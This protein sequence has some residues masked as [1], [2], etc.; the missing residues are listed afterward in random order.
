MGTEIDS[1]EI[2]IQADARSASKA[3]EQLDK[4][5][6]QVEEA[7]QETGNASTTGFSKLSKGAQNLTSKL[8]AA[9]GGLRD[10]GAPAV[11][12]TSAF[13]KTYLAV[14]TLSE[15]FDFLKDSIKSSMDAIET[16]NFY[17]VS[18]SKVGEEYAS[19]FE[20]FGYESA[21]A[22]VES[23]EDRLND[24]NKKLTGYTIGAQGEAILSNNVGLGL[25][26]EQMQSYQAQVLSFTNAIGLVG[27]ASINTTKA[28][29]MLSGDVASLTNKDLEG[30]MTDLR[31]VLQ[32]QS[33]AG[34]KYGWDTTQATLQQYALAEGITKSISE[35]TQAEKVQLRLLAVLDQSEVS[36]SDL[37]NTLGSVANQSRLTGQQI[38]NFSRT[39]GNLFLPAVKNVLPYINGMIIAMNNLFTTLGFDMYGDT[40]LSDLQDGITGGVIEGVED[41]EESTDSTTDSVNKLK[42]SLAGFDELAILN[43]GSVG[44]GVADGA[45]GVIDLTE[46]ITSA[47]T[48]YEKQWE[49]AFALA[50]NKAADFAEEI[51]VGL[52]G[53][54]DAAERVIPAVLG[55]GTAFTAYKVAGGFSA[56]LNAL[57]KLASP[58]GV[59]ALAA[60]SIV[61][62]SSAVKGLNDELAKEDLALRFGEVTLS[63]KDIDK[64]AEHIL[65][66]KSLEKVSRLLSELDKTSGIGDD[67][68]RIV[69]ELDRYNWSV[70]V[71][72]EIGEEY[73]GKYKKAVSDYV[74]EVNN[75]VTQQHYAATLGVNLF[76]SN[77]ETSA[78]I[79]NIVN[80]FYNQQSGKL[81]EL[82]KQL[83]EVTT[84]AWNDGLLTIDEVEA[85]TNIQQ[86]MASIQEQL[87]TSEFKARMQL[88]EMD[89]SGAE[90][91]PES[92]KKLVE[93]R[94]AL[95]EEYESELNE[96]LVFTLSQVNLAYQAKLDEASTEEA[97]KT[98]QKQ[99]D[100][101]INEIQIN[102]NKEVEQMM[103]NSLAFD[104]GTIAKT[105]GKDIDSILPE[106]MESIKKGT[107]ILGDGS[108]I[109]DYETLSRSIDNIL[110]HYSTDLRKALGKPGL[111]GLQD[112]L[113]N[114][115]PTEELEKI[116]N[117]YYEETGEVPQAI[118]DALSA[119]YAL[120]IINGSK[121]ALLKTMLLSADDE[122]RKNVLRAM[123]TLGIEYVGAFAEGTDI[124]DSVLNGAI[125]DFA[126]DIAQQIKQQSEVTDAAFNLGQEVAKSFSDGINS[127]AGSIRFAPLNYASVGARVAGYYTGGFPNTSEPFM[128]GERGPE[129]MGGMYGKT[130]VANNHSITE[131]IEEAAYRGMMRALHDGQTSGNVNV[132]LEGDANGLFR[133]VRNKANEYYN[134]NGR[135]AFKI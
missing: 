105:F 10:M 70:S 91:T 53:V 58:V 123:E 116:A 77:S 111:A 75:Y 45:S 23:F 79:Q 49:Q 2:R 33:R 7:L 3:L 122:D 54:A 119:K 127:F 65:D 25:D 24:L 67:I 32:G 125:S 15:G 8:T 16:A 115:M 39:I 22:Y 50:E 114:I 134:V 113:S 69:S 83:N 14:R 52:K 63:L 121:E 44:I 61:G 107:S 108:G 104:F 129:L 55:I 51:E 81:E 40:W 35:M 89:F 96:S 12:L 13:A 60:G 132:T 117:R 120:D 59:A 42:K 133:V 90:L 124:T 73:E 102:R 87:A 43:N 86:Q 126:D 84:N 76:L 68:T 31:S 100:E 88:L 92:F 99:W 93:K 41:L 80:S 106:I 6:G 11:N 47:L 118:A 94:N 26:I 97:K 29:S 27:E 103:L 5:L 95:F 20:Q 78:N 128:V 38:D 36:Y 57:S 110:S 135:P 4:K 56:L 66:N 48:D 72:L 71:G 109:F 101:A 18:L 19:N 62:V 82:G 64:I 9:S 130:A 74:E 17:N 34:Y 98:I 21:E 85:I 131:G 112:I 28:L 30:V 1:L 46:S 37:A